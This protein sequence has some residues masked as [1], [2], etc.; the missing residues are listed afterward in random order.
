MLGTLMTLCR[1]TKPLAPWWSELIHCRVSVGNKQESE[2]KKRTVVW[3]GDEVE[4]LS[5]FLKLGTVV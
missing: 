1:V 4:G 2:D 5:G 3:V